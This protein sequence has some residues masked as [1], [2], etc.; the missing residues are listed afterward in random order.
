MVEKTVA[1]MDDIG[2]QERFADWVRTH[3]EAVRGFIFARVRR[4]DAVEDMVQEVFCRAWEAKDR[5]Q[6]QGTA[7]PT[8]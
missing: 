1:S 7:W 4:P 3:G 5:Y 8:S 6:E 2:G